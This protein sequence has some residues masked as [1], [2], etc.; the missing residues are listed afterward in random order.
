[1]A[2]AYWTLAS[3]TLTLTLSAFLKDS[4]APKNSAT[5]WL[6]IAVVT[7][8]WPVT[9]PT[10]LGR[11]VGRLSQRSQPAAVENSPATSQSLSPATQ[12]SAEQPLAKAETLTRERIVKQ[13]HYV[14]H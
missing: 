4:D 3:L 10:I 13:I 14:K 12:L 7:L 9:L 1:M 2:I 11:K 8:L 6:F 5:H